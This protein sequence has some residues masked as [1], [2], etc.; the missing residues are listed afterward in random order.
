MNMCVFVVLLL[1]L[2]ISAAERAPEKPKKNIFEAINNGEIG[3]V[4]SLLFQD[5]QLIVSRDAKG[6]TPLHAALRRGNE[7]MV[8]HLLSVTPNLDNLRGE[9]GNT[10]LNTAV[11]AGQLAMVQL[12]LPLRPNPDTRNDKGRTALMIAVNEGNLPIAQLLLQYRNDLN[13]FDYENKTALM[14]AIEK[15]NV[16]MVRL[17]LEVQQ[18]GSMA[19]KFDGKALS[20][21]MD[22]L[23]EALRESDSYKK[24]FEQGKDPLDNAESLRYLQE[25]Q[26]YQTIMRDFV[27]ARRS[28]D[29]QY[30]QIVQSILDQLQEFEAGAIL[31]GRNTLGK[32]YNAVYQSLKQAWAR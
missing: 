16:A 7:E 10:P 2:F 29:A 8:R 12:L 20:F 18:P 3:R 9:K 24:K 11:E 30:R 14:I 25:A 22:K 13:F 6:D 19:Y 27:R 21:A 17:L 15:R 1:P 31:R 4:R 5:P 28:G 23:D 32:S 26:Q